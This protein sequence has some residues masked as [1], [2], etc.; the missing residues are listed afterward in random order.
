MKLT[1]LNREWFHFLGTAQEV[2]VLATQNKFVQTTKVQAG[3]VR[4]QCFLCE[5]PIKLTFDQDMRVTSVDLASNKAKFSG[6][7]EAQEYCAPGLHHNE[8]LGKFR[9]FETLK[10]WK[11]GNF[12]TLKLQKQATKY[13]DRF[14]IGN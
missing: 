1:T 7:W 13:L 3:I 4:A 5:K 6:R 10:P 8:L 9:N 12:E 14:L 11:L 2:R